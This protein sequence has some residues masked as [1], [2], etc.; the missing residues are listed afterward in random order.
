[1]H[2]GI[3]LLGDGFLL[4]QDVDC[5]LGARSLD[6]SRAATASSISRRSRAARRPPTRRSRP[7]AQ[8]RRCS[9]NSAASTCRAHGPGRNAGTVPRTAMTLGATAV[10][11]R[12]GLWFW[13][14]T[15]SEESADA[16][17]RAVVQGD[18]ARKARPSAKAMASSPGAGRGRPL[19]VTRRVKGLEGRQMPRLYLARGARSPPSCSGTSRHAQAPYLLGPHRPAARCRRRRRRARRQDGAGLVAG[20]SRP[21]AFAAAQRRVEPAR[22]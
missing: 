2:V 16:G 11:A 9:R 12:P 6:S 3:V 15:A 20:P 14:V 21:A 18:P 8:E 17:H 10:G 13:M 4:L 7:V 5:Q 22:R 19:P 1:M